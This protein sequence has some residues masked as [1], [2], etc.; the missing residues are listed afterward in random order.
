[1]FFLLKVALAILG[2][3]WFNMSFRTFFY[4]FE[5]VHW[6]FDMDHNECIESVDHLGS[7]EILTILIVQSMNTGYIYIYVC[8]G[9]FHQWFVV[10][11]VQIFHFVD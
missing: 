6:N 7:M 9:F 10:F 4:F 1:M 3:L 2:L 8:F 5:N 11:I